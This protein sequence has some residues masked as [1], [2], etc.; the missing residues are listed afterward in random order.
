MNRKWSRILLSLMVLSVA[1]TVSKLAFASQVYPAP[2]LDP[3]L[4]ISGLTFAGTG[5]ALLMERIRRRR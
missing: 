1:L 5:V 3:A 2:E 4:A